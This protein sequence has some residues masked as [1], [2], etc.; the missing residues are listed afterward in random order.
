MMSSLI[1]KKNI[2]MKKRFGFFKSIVY[3]KMQMV[4]WQEYTNKLLL[5]EDHIYMNRDNRIFRIKE[6]YEHL[7]RTID[8][9]YFYVK[10]FDVVK[11]KIFELSHNSELKVYELSFGYVCPYTKRNGDI[12]YKKLDNGR[13]LCKMHTSCKDRLKVRISENLQMLPKDLNSIIFKYILPTN[14]T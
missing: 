3:R 1:L 12:C 4:Y 8:I 11:N 14:I 13:L 6:I 5:E 2:Y 10:F 9:W 7:L